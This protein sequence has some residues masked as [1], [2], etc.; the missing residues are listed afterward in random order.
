VDF[1]D[2]LP[3]EEL[4]SFIEDEENFMSTNTAPG[5]KQRPEYRI[6]TK[7]AGV[8]VQVTFKGEVIADS[9]DAIELKEAEYPSV[10][11]FPRADVKMEQLVRSDHKTYCPFKGH[12]SYYSF[13]NGPVN[14]V[15]TYEEPYDEASVIRERLAFYPEKVDSIRVVEE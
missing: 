7:P 13:M 5:Y 14:A 9:R 12:A 2:R 6:T 1:Q 10:Y 8:R 11:Y 4:K 15:W 3:A